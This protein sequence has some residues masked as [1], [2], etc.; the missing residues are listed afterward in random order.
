LVII[1]ISR[2]VEIA[3]ES[4]ELVFYFLIKI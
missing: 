3:A 1:N 4:S 2:F